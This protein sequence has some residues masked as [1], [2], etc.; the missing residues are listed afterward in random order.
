MNATNM[1]TIERSTVGK[2]WIGKVV[3]NGYLILAFRLLLGA[4][5]MLSAVGKLVDIE[6]YSVDA[7]YNFAVLPLWLA[8][9]AGLIMPFIELGIALGLIFGVL[10]RL[11]ALGDA[12]L[13][14]IFFLVKLHVLFIQGR[15]ID[16]GCFGAI[17]TTMASVTIYMDIPMLVMGLIIMFAPAS[18]RHWISLARFVP[19]KLKDKLDLVW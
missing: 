14:L 2:G 9:P 19:Q 1:G 6:R 3:G 12:V 4:T 7:V 16:C 13:S 17:M 5:F 11:S 8:R 10:T 15:A 18:S